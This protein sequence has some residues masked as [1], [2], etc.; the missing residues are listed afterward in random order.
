MFSRLFIDPPAS[1]AWNMAV[2]ETLLESA[3]AGGGFTLRFYHW[4]EP[5][6]S[7][8]YFQQ[9]T[10][11]MQHVASRNCAAV[12]RATGGGAILHDREITYSIAVPPGHRLA[13][14]HIALYE[15]VH[16]VLIDV[17]AGYGIHARL[18]QGVGRESERSQPF[19]CFQRRSPGDV[20]LSDMKIAGSAQR[21]YR[22]AV[23]QHGSL[24]LARSTTAP[25]LPGISEIA[26]ISLSFDEFVQAWSIK[27]AEEFSMH[28]QPG[29]LTDSEQCNAKKLAQEKYD[30]AEWTEHRRRAI[31]KEKRS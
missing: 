31:D 4:Q 10:D 30:S 23:L 18:C 9:Y 7:L 12:R 11:R 2:D 13:V 22:G 26:A 24:L 29:M 16:A 28:F 15:T 27:L 1:G 25:E 5:T 6:L 20:L 21:R 8:G 19:L 17:L 14:K 3:A